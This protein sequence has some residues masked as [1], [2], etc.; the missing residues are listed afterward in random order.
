MSTGYRDVIVGWAI[1][2]AIGLAASVLVASAASRQRDPEVVSASASRG[3][4]QN[5]Y[6][7]P[8][9][10]VLEPDPASYDRDALERWWRDYQLRHANGQ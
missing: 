2:V 7:E 3:V 5:R 9:G 1:L 6:L 4:L 8:N 10:E